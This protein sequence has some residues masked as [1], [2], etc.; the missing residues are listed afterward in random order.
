MVFQ[1]I[2]SRISGHCRRLCL[3]NRITS[4][5]SPKPLSQ[6]A[7]TRDLFSGISENYQGPTRVLHN[8]MPRLLGNL[9]MKL[10]FAQESSLPGS[11]KFANSIHYGGPK[12]FERGM[13]NGPVETEKDS[14]S[15]QGSSQRVDQLNRGQ[16]PFGP[17]RST[18][19]YESLTR[20]FAD[21]DGTQAPAET[22]RD[23]RPFGRGFG[24][25]DF[26]R[27]MNFADIDGTR[28]PTE[29]GRDSRP[30]GRG[31]GLSEFG[32]NMNF[33]RGI[34]KD[35]ENYRSGL[36]Q[37]ADIVHIK[38]MRNNTFVTVT[39]SKGNKKMGSSAGCLA[40]MK[41]GPKVSKYSAEAT[42]EHVGRVAKNMGL[43]SVVMKVNGFTFF[44]KKKL[45]ILSFRDGYTNSR[46][47]RNPI[48]YIEDTTRK[49]H[50]G[51]RL[52]KQRRV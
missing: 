35:N 36:E 50:N 42:A 31:I 10:G 9:G 15:F 4:V 37:N 6:I 12:E 44:K 14:G 2:S 34:M 39:D 8:A 7:Q 51:C 22:G 13:D 16:S 48:V 27:N 11:L 3:P 46:S 19:L 28:A 30:F 1:R 43:K 33:A 47:D 29:T 38:I 21:M 5:T 24:L 18:G 23:S 41:G 32:R 17:G 25:S 20:R 26:G 49:P 45:A 52:R 40:E